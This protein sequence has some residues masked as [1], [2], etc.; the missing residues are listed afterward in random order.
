VDEGEMTDQGGSLISIAREALA[1]GMHFIL[2]VERA[3]LRV[4]QK[5]LGV[6]WKKIMDEEQFRK[7]LMNCIFSTQ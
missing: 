2:D 5:T 1:L 3:G 6:N 4:P 7:I